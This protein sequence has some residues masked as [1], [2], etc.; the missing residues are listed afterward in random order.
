M[1]TTSTFRVKCLAQGHNTA[2]VGFEPPTSRSRVQHSTT[3]PSRSPQGGKEKKHNLSI[4]SCTRL[5]SVNNKLRKI[6][7]I[8]IKRKII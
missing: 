3:E 8:F 5:A 4:F 1:G 2:E 7:T 6:A